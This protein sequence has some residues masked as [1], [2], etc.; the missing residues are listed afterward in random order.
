MRCS[1]ALRVGAG[2]PGTSS[3]R[4]RPRAS[5]SRVA[6]SGKPRSW[7]VRSAW[8]TGKPPIHSNAVGRV[9]SWIVRP[10]RD[11]PPRPW[12]V[13]S[14]TA[15]KVGM[16]LRRNAAVPWL[17]PPRR[18]ATSRAARMRP[19][20]VSA[21]WPTAYTPRYTP[22]SRPAATRRSIPV[23]ETP[24]ASSCARVTTPSCRAAIAAIA[25]SLTTL[26]PLSGANVVKT[27]PVRAPHDGDP[28]RPSPECAPGPP[29]GRAARAKRHSLRAKLL[30]TAPSA[31]RRARPEA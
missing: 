31:G 27:P 1:S 28:A 21:A 5:A 23:L 26:T 17:A 16:R 7:R 22:N 13:R 15:G 4:T 3:G 25:W 29:R 2:P 18:P 9:V 14:T 19:R 20:S 24:A 11:R 30:R 8:V 6:R 12:T 10:G